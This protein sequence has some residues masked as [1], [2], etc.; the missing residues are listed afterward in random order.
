MTWQKT[1]W[2]IGGGAEHTAALARVLAYVASGGSEGVVQP[3]DLKVRQ[4]GSPSGSVQID[5]GAALILNRSGGGS[6]QAYAGYNPTADSVAIGATSTTGGRSD[7]VIARVEDPEFSPWQRPADMKTGQFIFTRVIP[8]VPAGT[9]SAEELNLGYSALA[10]AR[11]DIPT[12]TTAITD[13]MIKDVRTLVR[14]RRETQIFNAY[15]AAANDLTATSSSSPQVWP[16]AANTSVRIPKWATRAQIR[17][18]LAGVLAI[19]G[20]TN[21]GVGVRLGA[22][23]VQNS[24]FNM[25]Q[26][27]RGVIV[28]AGAVSIPAGMRGTTVGLQATGYRNTSEAGTLRADAGTS[29]FITI[30][31]IEA[32]V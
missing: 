12:A 14:P 29:T 5:P 8:N 11:I 4:T 26:N 7:L 20:P 10:L 32:P 22:L 31:F 18:D 15:P 23:A 30:E 24:A 28:A 3:G 25:P 19:T 9:V 21:G 16:A 17:L 27:D 1:P 13:A 6:N 2:F